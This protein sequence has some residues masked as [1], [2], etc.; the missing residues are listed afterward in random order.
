MHLIE[1]HYDQTVFGYE[2]VSEFSRDSTTPEMAE[3]QERLRSTAR[4]AA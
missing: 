3:A 4:M 1:I 2:V